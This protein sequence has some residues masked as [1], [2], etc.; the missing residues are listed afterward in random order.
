[1]R[2]NVVRTIIE[3]DSQILIKNFDLIAKDEPQEELE[4]DV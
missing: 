2:E 1:M 3:F 4:L